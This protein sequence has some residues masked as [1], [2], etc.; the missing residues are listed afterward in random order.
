MN[1]S[2]FFVD[3]I[4]LLQ[5]NISVLN[6]AKT[7]GAMI[8]PLSDLAYEWLKKQGLDCKNFHEYEYPGI[9]DS[10]MFSAQEYGC[11]W[12]K[13]QGQK[14]DFTVFND[15]SAG[16]LI[17]RTMIY[18]FMD[19]LKILSIIE[20]IIVKEKPDTILVFDG[21]K[22]KARFYADIPTIKRVINLLAPGIKTEYIKAQFCKPDIINEFLSLLKGVVRE[23]FSCSNW[24][25]NAARKNI[26]LR[27]S[28]SFKKIVF[29]EGFHHV[30]TAFSAIKPADNIL[31]VH[32]QDKFSPK[33]FSTIVKNNAIIEDLKRYRVKN[34]KNIFSCDIEKAEER[35]K[36]YFVFRN[37]NFFPVIKE[38]IAHVLSHHIPHVV[39]PDILNCQNYIRKNMPD[40]IV[41]ENDSAY[42]QRLVIAC[43]KSSGVKTIVIQHGISLGGS[44]GLNKDFFC[45]DFYPITADKFLAWGEFTKDWFEKKGAKPGSVILTG[46]SRFDD[47]YIKSADDINELKAKIN[48]EGKAIVLVA[49]SEFCKRHYIPKYHYSLYEGK[50]HLKEILKVAGN[51]SNMLFIVRPH[52]SDSFTLEVLRDVVKKEQ[53]ENVFIDRSINLSKLLKIIDVCVGFYSTVLAEAM[54]C[55]VPVVTM[56][57]DNRPEVTPYGEYN[58]CEK[59]NSAAELENALRKILNGSEAF[60]NDLKERI[61]SNIHTINYKHDGKAAERIAQC[62]SGI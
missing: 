61:K 24:L 39:V 50:R 25:F 27:R 60:K 54:I 31:V 12:Y 11:Q 4:G 62:L 46:S 5:H 52:S 21:I 17:E 35:L 40:V 8:M 32:L 26:S 47:Y 38:R 37:K 44:S 16:F 59:A 22:E 18:Y 15:I 43:G 1:K 2:I 3:D 36:D 41:A 7:Q 55:E 58:L 20:A 28:G 33:T 49:L 6:A 34:N 45:A 13:T 51:N 14:E 9:Y 30:Q 19:T 10:I 56:N 57:F 53:L 42:K 23:L 48:P 29:Y